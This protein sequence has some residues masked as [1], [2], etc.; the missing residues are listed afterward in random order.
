AMAESRLDAL[1]LLRATNVIYTTGYFHLSTERPLAVLIPRS[2]QP[3]LFIPQLESDQ[4]KLWWVK[5]YEAYFD[6][7]GPIDRVRWIFER[8]AKRGFGSGRIGTDESKTGSLK[9]MAL[10]APHANIVEAGDLIEKMRWVKDLDELQVMRRAMYFA[11]FAVQSGREFVT[12]HASIQE[13]QILKATADALADKMSAEL[14]EVVGVGI[15]PPFGGLVPFGKRSAFP[16]AVPSK[17]R[18]APGDA[19]ILSYSAQVGGYNV[20]CERSFSVGNPTDHAKRLFEAMLAAHDA[21][22]ANMK[23]GAIAQ[24][25][26]KI[27][28]DQIRKAGFEKFLR[29]R[30]GHG[31]GLEGHESPWIAE[32]DTT[33]LRQGMTFSCEPGVYDPDWGGFRHSDTVIV[34]EDKGE[35]MNTYPTRL[36]DMIIAI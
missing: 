19:L 9:Q 24:A 21:G 5:D 8:V 11:D 16:H 7:P 31:I 10:G 35:I 17:D 23:E 12:N 15:E 28:L 14:K 2:G 4:V 18:L 30:T 34:R 1:V 27:S 3:A 32:G 25:V 22:V 26:D 29:H 36:E 6:F 33:V 13:D 20:E